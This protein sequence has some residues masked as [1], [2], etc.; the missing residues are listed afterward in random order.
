MTPIT[1]SI[2]EQKTALS[3]KLVAPMEQLAKKCAD[4]WPD[5]AGLD[6]VLQEGLSSIPLCRLAYAIDP[7]GTQISANVSAQG[8]S[9]RF[10][11]QDLSH[12]PFMTNV[13]PS[14][15]F[16]L[17]DVYVS[18]GTERPTV[19][20]VLAVLK[21]ERV[22]GFIAA[23]FDLRD[24][25]LDDT[26][27]F[28]APT[29][30]QIKGD[31]SIRQ[32]VFMQQRAIS[33]LDQHIDDVIAT[34]DE[35]MCERGIFHVQIHFS[36]SRA[37]LWSMDDPFSY[38]VH[39]LDEIINPAVCLA[40]RKQAYPARATVRPE[41]VRKVLEKFRQLR[42]ADDVIYLRSGSL[43]IINGIVGLTFSCDGS[44][45]IPVDEFL[46]DECKF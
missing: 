13:L 2:E 46:S 20:A 38:R 30:R 34:I 4:I 40:F 5:K 1:S 26:R 28:A 21:D 24:L 17:S 27:P 25:T 22:A 29:W 9:E 6:R 37:T 32:T 42:I 36:S 31:P 44:H 12:R 11:G 8:L 3:A 10:Y 18:R 16:I 19:T 39:V 7:S 23:D 43:N 45:Y 15:G 35:L 33:D 41:Q 14:R